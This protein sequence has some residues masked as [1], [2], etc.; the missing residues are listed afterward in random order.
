MVGCRDRHLAFEAS[1]RPGGR[2]LGCAPTGPSQAPNCSQEI[3]YHE[4]NLYLSRL[5]VRVRC[6]AGV[7]GDHGNCGVLVKVVTQSCDSHQA[8]RKHHVN[9][10]ARSA[11][12]EIDDWRSARD[13]S[14]ELLLS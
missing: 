12:R 1:S 9:I 2:L 4:R 6:T 3:R 7:R 13:S 11:T 8:R 14:K 5:G 10:P